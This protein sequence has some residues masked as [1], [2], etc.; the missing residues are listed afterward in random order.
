MAD[1][2]LV[3]LD[4]DGEELHLGAEEAAALLTLT[5]DFDAATVSACP[6]CRSRVLACVAVVDLLDEA[7]PHP[8][9]PEL[10]ELAEDAPT[11]HVYVHDLATTC[12]HRM[13]R[14]PGFVEWSEVLAEFADA[15]RGMR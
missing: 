10:V 13:W 11:L 5:R 8:R 3:I 9:I 6:S 14:D 2:G 7:P 4:E 12:G 15:R 1:D